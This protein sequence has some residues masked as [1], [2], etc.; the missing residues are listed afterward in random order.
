MSR[1]AFVFSTLILAAAAPAL[2]AENHACAISVDFAS[3]A[4]GVDT[5]LARRIAQ[6]IRHDPRIVRRERI[7]K[8]KEGEFELCLTVEPAQ[9]ARTVFRSIRALMPASSAK[10]P[11]TLTLKGGRKFETRWRKS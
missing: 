1:L 4:S 5:A 11:T 8:G 7:V 9:K 3:A 6:H 2:A 10:A